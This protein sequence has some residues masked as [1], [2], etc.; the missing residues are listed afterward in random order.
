MRA[1][2]LKQD[3][4]AHRVYEGAEAIGLADLAVPQSGEDPGKGLLPYIF[5]R[6]WRIEA[7]AELELD[8]FGEIRDEM[9]LRAEVSRLKTFNVGLV[10]GLELQR[11]P[12]ADA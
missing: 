9:L 7:R 6:L 2:M 4:V 12:L 10:K 8:Q 1:V 11:P 3:V 5:N